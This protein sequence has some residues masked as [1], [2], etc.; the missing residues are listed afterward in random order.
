MK[1]RLYCYAKSGRYGSAHIFDLQNK[2]IQTAINV[3]GVDE[4]IPFRWEHIDD[5]F[6]KENPNESFFTTF[7]QYPDIITDEMSTYDNI[8][9]Y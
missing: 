7:L 8:I 9:N 2:T 1:I 5:K 4:A 6:K 3:A